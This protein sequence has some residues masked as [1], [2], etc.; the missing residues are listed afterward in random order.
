[1]FTRGCDCF[2][3]IT[4]ADQNAL[5]S[6]C[7]GAYATTPQCTNY[8]VDLMRVKVRKLRC[9]CSKETAESDADA[10]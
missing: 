6:E 4:A 10:D 1:M 7:G 3:L 8:N 9:E 5:W 2:E